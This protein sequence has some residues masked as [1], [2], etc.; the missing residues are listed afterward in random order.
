MHT[1]TLRN[2]P[3]ALPSNR[4]AGFIIAG[5]DGCDMV[6]RSALLFAV[7]I[8]VMVTAGCT[9]SSSAPA[10]LVT[11]PTPMEPAAVATTSGCANDV[12]SFVPSLISQEGSTS[13]RLEAAPLR[14]SPIMSSTP[15]IQLAPNTTG[16]NVS[17]ASFMWNASY[18]EFLS[19]NPPDY[20]VNRRGSAVTGSNGT[21]YWTFIDK[22]VSTAE[23]VVITAR[24]IDPATGALLGTSTVTLAWDGDYA[25]T[26]QDIR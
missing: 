7:C 9:D 3:D 23:P 18:G 15:G 13:L 11:P 1:I 24:A 22:P 8:T 12:C 19:W 2:F 6:F 26:V 17:S 14:Y 20:T 10:P 21:L 16:F 25:V 4:I 5:S